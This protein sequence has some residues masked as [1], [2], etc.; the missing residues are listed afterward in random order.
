MFQEKWVLVQAA[1]HAEIVKDATTIVASRT[2]AK[3]T[4]S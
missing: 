4:P 2:P 3:S 1:E